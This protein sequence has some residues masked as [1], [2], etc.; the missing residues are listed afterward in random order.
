MEIKI[1]NYSKA[2]GSKIKGYLHTSKK[3]KRNLKGFIYNKWYLKLSKNKR[4]VRL[5]LWREFYQAESRNCLHSNILN[6]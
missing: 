1:N 5:D 3:E 6:L 4:H 2:N